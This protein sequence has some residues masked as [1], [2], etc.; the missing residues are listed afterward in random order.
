[1]S[2]ETFL[3]REAAANDPVQKQ[4][5]PEVSKH[6]SD[7][8]YETKKRLA[9]DQKAIR[10]LGGTNEITPHTREISNV[11][12]NPRGA[13]MKDLQEGNY[14]NGKNALYGPRKLAA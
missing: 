13:V 4:T 8:A 14:T 3:Q 10:L 6:D 7:Q 11:L 1:M 12:W 2:T 9:L 5:F